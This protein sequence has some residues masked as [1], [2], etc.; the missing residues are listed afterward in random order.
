MA[1]LADAAKKVCG[2]VGEIDPSTLSRMDDAALVSMPG[3]QNKCSICGSD[4]PLTFEHIPPRRCF[5]EKSVL[6]HTI[7][8]FMQSTSGPVKYRRGLGRESLCAGCNGWTASV[9][10]GAYASWAQRAMGYV[11]VGE[12]VDRML[13]PYTIQPLEAIKQVGSMV[14]AVNDWPNMRGEKFQSLRR[15]VR[16]PGMSGRPAGMRFYAYLMSRGDLR[17]SPLTVRL[18]VAGIKAVSGSAEIAFPPLGFV[19]LDDGPNER[20]VARRLGLQDVTVFFERRPL[21][22]RTE[23]LTMTRLSPRGVTLLDY[24]QNTNSPVYLSERGAE[25][26]AGNESRR[27]SSA[28]E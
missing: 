12:P 24:E 1:G 7:W 3:T 16:N 4:G 26:R 14:L 9:Y 20:E 27:R 17:L 8:S 21:S 11:A 15:L 5:N 18:M 2:A 13:L 19:A 22:L 25:R 10:G 28:E 6:L 23:W